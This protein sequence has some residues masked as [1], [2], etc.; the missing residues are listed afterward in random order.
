MAERLGQ[1]DVA[2]VIDVHQGGFLFAPA[3]VG[4]PKLEESPGI[5]LRIWNIKDGVAIWGPIKWQM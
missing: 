5:F 4:A 1:G 2:I 3:D